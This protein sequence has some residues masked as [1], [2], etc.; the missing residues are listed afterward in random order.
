MSQISAAS[1]KA[2]RDRTDM[3]MMD[4][5]AALTEANGDVEQAVL[6]LRKKGKGFIDRKG[7]RETAEGRIAAYSDP[8][9]SSGAIIELRCESPSVVKN[10]R[11]VA[12]A[13]DLAKQVAVKNP[14]TVE[15]L[16]KQPF[17]DEPSRTVQDRIE[18]VVGLIRE[19]MKPARFTRLPGP[20]GSYV[21]HDGQIGV[22]LQVKGEGKPDP[23]LLRDICAHVAALQPAYLKES[24][25]P[26]DV[27][28][29]EKALAREQ[30]AAQAAGKPANI[31]EKIAEG[32]YKTWMGENVLLEQPMAN[33]GK[34]SKKT[35]GQL[36]QAA[37]LD[38]VKVVRYKVGGTS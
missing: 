2:L 27:V 30:T 10:D 11:F 38:V 34:Y 26:A 21:H 1:V 25:I 36:L 16:V 8:A 19:N 35:V 15:D 9:G 22:L 3:P 5:K 12:L 23:E 6:I 17:V 18:D 33:Q 32:K 13:N 20:T 31:V 24:E 28:T 4:C 14:A 29:R 7:D 37:K